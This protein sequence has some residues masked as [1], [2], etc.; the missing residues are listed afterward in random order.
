MGT[1]H[2]TVN[3]EADILKTLVASGYSL[4]FAT[5]VGN[6]YN[7]A[8]LTVASDRL[9][10]ANDIT[11][12]T[13]YTIAGTQQ[14]FQAGN[15]VEKGRAPALPIDFGQVY[16]LKSWS[17]EPVVNTSSVVPT[18]A[19]GLQT[20][21]GVDAAAVI[22][23]NIANISPTDPSP[24]YISPIE[25]PNS[26]STFTPIV[27]VAL[28]FQQ[29]IST[30]TMIVL[31]VSQAHVMDFTNQQTRITTYKNDG[32]WQDGSS[33]KI[34]YTQIAPAYLGGKPRKHTQ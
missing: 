14:P 5:N 23:L 27:K 10:F 18:N 1:Y 29:N 33:R 3:I 11:W 8:A 26:L 12:T 32:T 13:S 9:T 25:I 6:Q 24:I 31:S 17:S 7:V 19:L 28:W 2:L 21:T 15:A 34:N 20:G 22:S 30:S 16:E 4:C